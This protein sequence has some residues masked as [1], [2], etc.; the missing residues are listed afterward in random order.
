MSVLLCSFSRFEFIVPSI[1]N[2]KNSCV[3]F[4]FLKTDSGYHVIL[5]GAGL[6]VMRRCQ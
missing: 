4:P 2:V 6:G 5:S 3:A 1:I